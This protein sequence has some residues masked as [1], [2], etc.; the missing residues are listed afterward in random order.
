[1]ATL[2]MGSLQTSS[3]AQQCST[4]SSVVF[5]LDKTR[6]Y[7]QH[8][9]K[10][11]KNHERKRERSLFFGFFLFELKLLKIEITK[12]IFEHFEPFMLFSSSVGSK[13]E[14]LVGKM[15]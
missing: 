11:N 10:N 13:D 8:N 3:A 2:F 1:M 12:T 14:A 6:L 5:I 4:I 15:H 9:S 7:H